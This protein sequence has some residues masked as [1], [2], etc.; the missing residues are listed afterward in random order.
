MTEEEIAAL[1][2]A[3]GPAEAAARIPAHDESAIGGLAFD[4]PFPPARIRFDMIG[5]AEALPM[6][7]A[8]GTDQVPPC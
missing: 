6:R 1:L 4:L 8:P 2:K 3:A 5:H 7:A